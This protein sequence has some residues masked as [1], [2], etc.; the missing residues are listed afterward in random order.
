MHDRPFSF[1][2]TARPGEELKVI[3]DLPDPSSSTRSALFDAVRAC[4]SKYNGLKRPKHHFLCHLPTDMW[5]YGPMRGYW[6]F[7]FE[8]FNSIIKRG[9]A[10]SGFKH[11]SLSC[12]R[13][14][15]MRSG[16]ACAEAGAVVWRA[17]EREAKRPRL[18]EDCD[19]AESK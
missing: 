11:E 7:G 5:K 12:M 3:D 1:H 6:C 4:P 16:R 18:C 19:V 13:W 9:A 2:R 15:S 10:R 8:A 17:E 14:S